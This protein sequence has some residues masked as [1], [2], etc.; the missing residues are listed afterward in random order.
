MFFG[1]TEFKNSTVRHTIPTGEN[2]STMKNVGCVCVSSVCM[3]MGMG[4]EA[5]GAFSKDLAPSISTCV[6][7]LSE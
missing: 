2:G 7:H 1:T 6:K 4:G 3:G 5:A